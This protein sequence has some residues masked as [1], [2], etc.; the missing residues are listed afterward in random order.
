VRLD[1]GQPGIGQGIKTALPLVIAEELEVDWK[2]VRILQGDLDPAC[3]GQ[4][5][6]GSTSTPD[7]QDDFL[8]QGA[9]ALARLVQAAALAWKVQPGDGVAGAGTVRHTASGR[10]LGYG[11]L[12]TRTA[13]LELTGCA[14]SDSSRRSG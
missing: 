6:G 1:S 9:T 8:R 10:Q 13:A 11:D 7:N 14:R 2:D 12:A 5:A 3:G 4:G